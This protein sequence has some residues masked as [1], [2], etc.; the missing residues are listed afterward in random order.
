MRCDT[1]VLDGCNKERGKRKKKKK[2][3][4]K[5]ETKERKITIYSG[6]FSVQKSLNGRAGE[7]GDILSAGVG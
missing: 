2:R 4:K 6:V 3:E 7:A 5:K 1:P